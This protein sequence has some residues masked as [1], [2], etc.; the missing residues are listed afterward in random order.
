MATTFKLAGVG[1]INPT[2]ALIQ[3]TSSSSANANSLANPT[4][5]SPVS[6]IIANASTNFTLTL[7]ANS[8]SILRLQASG[9]GFPSN[10]TLQ[11]PSPI[12]SDQAVAATVGALQYGQ[13]TNLTANT[14]HGI[15]Y[16]SANTAIA[17]VDNN[18]NVT[19]VASGTTSI[20]ATYAALGLSAT[21]S[22]QV[23]YVP[24]SLTHRYS[25]SETSGTTVAD[26]VGGAAWNGT[27]PNGGTLGGG[28]FP[29]PR[30]ASN[31]SAC[32]AAF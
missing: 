12:Y 7:P 21:Q 32:R 27:L 31:T 13:W 10:L 14:N 17:T 29:F 15:T 28:Q 23:I 30:P 19:G 2:G 1:S 6:N 18:G 5:V 8:L 24:T 25:F 26:S 9:I 16:S 11:V 4:Y 20:I 3:L 22:V